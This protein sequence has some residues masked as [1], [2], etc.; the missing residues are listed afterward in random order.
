MAI[1]FN[2]PHC[3]YAYSL[4]D[5]FAGKQ[6][7]CKNP[8]C[9][10]LIT[11]PTPIT[12][13]D[14]DTPGLS[15]E[16][17]EAAA[18]AALADEAPKPEEKPAEKT[19]PMVCK[20]CDHKW[21]VPWS[22]AGK[23][24]LC[25]NPECR[26]RVK[27]PEPQEDV[28]TDWRQQKS[29]LPSMAKQNYEKPEDVQD[30]ADAKHI[31]SQTAKDAGLLDEEIEP[32][33]LKDKLFNVFLAV[34]VFG[35]I[36][37]G[38]WY[39]TTRRT[40]V[41]EEQLMADARKELDQ[42]RGELPEGDLTSAVLDLAATEYAL[43]HDEAKKLKEAQ[44][45]FA[46]GV[47]EVRGTPGQAMAPLRNAMAAEFALAALAFG[48]TDEQAKEQL[49]F[50]WQPDTDTGRIVKMS[51]RTHTVH[52][53]L[54]QTLALLPQG[55]AELD[56]RM[57]LARQLTRQLTKRGQ[58]GM[59]ADFIPLALFTEA[60]RDEARGL[61]ALELYR[62]DKNSEI[63]RKT[64]EE[65]KTRYSG[66]KPAL[67]PA[68]VQTLFAILSVDKAPPMTP[69]PPGNGDLNSD[70]IRMA[71]VGKLLLDSQ[72]DEALKLA[73]R[74]GK[75]EHQLK[76][77][78]LC[79]EWTGEPGPALEAAQ[80]LLAALK[81]KKEPPP[82]LV[83]RLVQ[84]AATTGKFEQANTL[85]DTLTDESLKAWA[86]GD[87]VRLRIASLPKEKANEAWAEAPD[88][89]KLQKAGQAW[90]RLWVARQNAKLSHNRDAEKKATALW[91]QGIHPFALAGIALGLQDK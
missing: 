35:S 47:R 80:T 73:T 60:E 67:A 82:Y 66:A 18:L 85:A 86:K 53:L 34:A 3:L 37:L 64:A 31:S 76:A 87:A 26:Q 48:G 24:T 70:L 75:P 9:R 43:R 68:S 36:A 15:H 29:K 28:P 91:S 41:Q 13:P 81:G 56:L 5:K 74:P 45:V 7:K 63:A 22:L 16:E 19:I 8:E 44:E 59:A 20:F 77:L 39:L 17:A 52:E 57:S 4:P 89:L 46:R 25:P 50:R 40:V 1:A 51:E 30:A 42:V 6:A 23:N 55:S 61:V 71:H 14:D 72:P 49:R 65:L 69:L 90:A 10:K 21:E 83:L 33:S 11:I 54:S 58:A 84:I 2:C 12:I 79:A 62:A 32:R 27:V 78:V 88:N 38:I